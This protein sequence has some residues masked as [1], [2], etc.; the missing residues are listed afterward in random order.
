M[1]ASP[2]VRIYRESFLASPRFSRG[3]TSLHIRFAST[4]C[5]LAQLVG[6]IVPNRIDK[7]SMEKCNF[8]Y[9]LHWNPKLDRLLVL[10]SDFVRFGLR[11]CFAAR[12]Q[13]WAVLLPLELTGKLRKNVTFSYILH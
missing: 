10:E 7:K 4:V 8:S 6:T 9:I 11:E 3:R 2:L 12:D 1:A 13:L 5:W